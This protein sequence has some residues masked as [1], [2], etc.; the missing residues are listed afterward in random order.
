MNCFSVC[1]ILIANSMLHSTKNILLSV[2]T[3]LTIQNCYSQHSEDRL[4]VQCGADVFFACG[5]DSIKGKNIAVVANK[6]SRLRNGI[7]IID[8]LLSTDNILLKAVFT[9]EHGFESKAEAGEI[10]TESEYKA[11]KVYSL[12]GSNKK[13]SPKSLTGIDIILFD[14]QDA[15]TRFYTYISTLYYVIEAAAENKLN[16]IVLDRPNPIGGNRIS[17]PVLKTELR[18][19][20]GIAEIPIVYGMTIG[21]LALMFNEIIYSE[22][23]IKADLKIIEMQNWERRYYYDD[24]SL[25]WINPSPNMISAE[26]AIVYPGICL[27]EGTNIS[28]GRGTDT[29]FQIFGAP[30]IDNAQLITELANQKI[31]GAE[32][33]PAEFTPSD[34]HGMASNPKYENTLCRGVKIK[35]TDKNLFEPVEC[36]IKILCALQKLFP[37]EFKI[38]S[39]HFDKLTGDPDIRNW[40]ISGIPAEEIIG[41]WNEELNK[42]T[43]ERNKFLIYK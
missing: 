43:S 29:P 13:P 23:K 8:T 34:L 20:I 6:T 17:G 26:T 27:L 24:C 4:P 32:F 31:T 9:P 30:F 37:G 35:I 5:I 14:L 40:I 7:H 42:F 15:G 10:I 19:F 12:Y 11:L 3:I 36:G 33:I 39:S 21:E 1:R 41:Q 18:S 16:L 2:I 22:K 38:E 25:D 28:E